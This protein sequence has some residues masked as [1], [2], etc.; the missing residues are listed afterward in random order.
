L[1]FILTLILLFVMPQA[2]APQV[3]GAL[4]VVQ[5]SDIHYGNEQYV[6]QAWDDA[7]KKGKALRPDI[8]VLTGDQADNK[9]TPEEFQKRLRGFGA[10]LRIKLGQLKRPMAIALGNNDVAN[11]YQTD[12]DNLGMSTR[13]YRQTL[14]RLYYLDDLGNGVMPST[15]GGMTWITLNSLMFSPLNK[16]AE[17]EA[18]ARQTLDF[19]ASELGK[20]PKGRPVVIVTHIPPTYDLYDKKPAWH[21][22]DVE[23]FRSVLAAHGGPAVVMA[24]HFHRNEVHA[25]A[26][27]G[28]WTVPVLVAGSLSFKYG[29]YPNW[30]SY[31]WKTDRRGHL[32]TVAYR[33][34]YPLQGE[35]NTFWTMAAPLEEP[36]W[37]SFA[38]RLV[39]S[40]DIYL[41]YMLDLYAHNVKWQEWAESA[42]Q[43]KSVIDEIWVPDGAAVR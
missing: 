4:V 43:R 29:N 10:D 24:G 8:V 15:V 25:L 1:E 32:E 27:P 36:S 38:S 37:T 26:L 35:W 11:N 20:L 31:A 42:D 33:I 17:R 16:Y 12:P 40:K 7:Y 6:A 9:C 30:R 2:A 28:K 21:A 13:I 5:W 3:K 18:Q 14:G 34:R 41:K 23:R 39:E 22:A 19:L